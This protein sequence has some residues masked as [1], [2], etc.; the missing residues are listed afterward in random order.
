[1]APVFGIS[2]FGLF[3][4]NLLE[5]TTHKLQFS[6]Q[7]E[8]KEAASNLQHPLVLQ[9]ALKSTLKNTPFLLCIGFLGK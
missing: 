9:L 8:V 1:M 4:S 6:L 2:R 7:M 3:V 5:V